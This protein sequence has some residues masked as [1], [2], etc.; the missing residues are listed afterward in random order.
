MTVP[1]AESFRNTESRFVDINEALFQQDRPK[2]DIVA[3][4]TEVS[5]MRCKQINESSPHPADCGI[6]VI[7]LVPVDADVELRKCNR[8][9]QHFDRRTLCECVG[10]TA[11]NDR[12]KVRIGDDHGKHMQS[13]HAQ[14]HVALDPMPCQEA[15]DNGVRHSRRIGNRVLSALERLE[16][17]SRAVLGVA[18]TPDA[19]IALLKYQPLKKA[20]GEIVEKSSR[21][22][23]YTGA[24]R[25]A[26]IVQWN[27]QYARR[28]TGGLLLQEFQQ[29][30]QEYCLPHVVHEK[31][32]YSR[33]GQ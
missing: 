19:D 14:H 9:R 13:G 26:G 2:A 20:G 16:R 31:A 25:G 4:S 12:Q 28:C 27:W 22:I 18:R 29:G 15:V 21:K 3:S 24:Q 11:G 8:W 10:E 1:V 33:G 5:S 6:V 17:H 32:E 30:R 23:D 7:A